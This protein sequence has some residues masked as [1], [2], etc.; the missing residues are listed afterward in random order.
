MQN[1]YYGL[2]SILV[3]KSNSCKFSNNNGTWCKHVYFPSMHHTDTVWYFSLCFV[4]V[5]AMRM[6]SRLDFSGGWGAG[7]SW[8][9]SV[10]APA[11]KK[12]SGEVCLVVFLFTV[13]LIF[14]SSSV[15]Q[16]PQGVKDLQDAE[17]QLSLVSPLP[18][19]Y[20]WIPFCKSLF[21]SVMAYPTTTGP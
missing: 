18:S 5:W 10:P 15:C 8:R 14:V 13:L 12:E 16:R 21:G 9:D 17:Q 4:Y 11:V 20:S 2:G 19:L 6:C 1:N 7:K 3:L